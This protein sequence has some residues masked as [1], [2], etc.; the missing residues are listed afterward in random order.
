MVKQIFGGCIGYTYTDRVF[1]VA[2]GLEQTIQ[3]IRIDNVP[4][5][6]Y[7]HVGLFRIVVKFFVLIQHLRDIKITQ[8]FSFVSFPILWLK[9]GKVFL[10]DSLS[11]GGMFDQLDP[12]E[13]VLTSGSLFQRSSDLNRMFGLNFTSGMSPIPLCTE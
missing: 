4:T 10:E 5:A 8:P 9:H 3:K 12:A 11:G 13:L 7:N 6:E 1:R 2:I